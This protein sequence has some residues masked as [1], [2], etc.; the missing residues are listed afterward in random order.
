VW[1]TPKTSCRPI[2]AGGPERV[3]VFGIRFVRHFQFLVLLGPTQVCFEAL[4]RA[5]GPAWR[6][7]STRAFGTVHSIAQL[8]RT[9]ANRA[10]LNQISICK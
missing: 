7:V 2:F 1:Y 5:G 6:M 9:R 10:G 3:S 4:R 8:N